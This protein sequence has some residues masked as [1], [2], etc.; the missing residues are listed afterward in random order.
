MLSQNLGGYFEREKVDSIRLDSVKAFP[1]QIA[2]VCNEYNGSTDE[3]FLLAAK[4]SKKV[5][6]YGEPTMGALDYSNINEVL[7]PDG[8]YKMWITMSKSYRIPDFCIDGVGV[9]PDYYIDQ[10]IP[11]DNWINFVLNRMEN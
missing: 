4:Q 11:E 3:E 5:K 6:I 10:T 9:Q 1:N 7:S 8:K 2:I